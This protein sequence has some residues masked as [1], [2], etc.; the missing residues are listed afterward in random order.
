[1]FY[2]ISKILGFFLVPSNLLLGVGLVGIILMRSRFAQTGTRLAVAS[3]AL[4]LMVG[5]FPIGSALTLPLEARFPPWQS[6]SDPPT[7][8]IVLG[9]VIDSSI[10]AARG[11]VALNEAAERITAAVELA[12]R[13]PKARIVFS[14]GEA[15][16]AARLLEDLGVPRTRITLEAYARST[17][18]NAEFTEK[19]VAPKSGER[20]LLVTSAMHMPRAIGAFRKVGFAVEAYPVNYRTVGSGDLWRIPDSLLGG[21]PITDKAVHEWLGLLG[22]WMTGRTSALFP[23]PK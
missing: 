20:W 3:I 18:E 17:A 8:I 4:L 6:G 12:R 9:G 2:E 19:R 22:Y 23:A 11:T 5:V 10:S 7:G 14:G 13:F 16:Y 1:M 15:T 21:I